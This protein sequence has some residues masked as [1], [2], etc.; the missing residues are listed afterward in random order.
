MTPD[1]HRLGLR[2]L[3]VICLVLGFSHL[4]VQAALPTCQAPAAVSH[5]VP[6]EPASHAANCSVLNIPDYPP[7]FGTHYGVWAKFQTY[8][9]PVSTGFWLHSAEH[10]AVV[11]L[12]K[13]PAGCTEEV[14]ALKALIETLPLDTACSNHP[15]FGAKRRIIMTPDPRLDSAFAI[16]A[17]GWS[18]KTNCLDTAALRAFYLA[19]I[20]Q[21]PEDFCNPGVDLSGS[22]WCN[23]TNAIHNQI[24]ARNPGTSN[25]IL[26]EG[27]L[28]NQVDLVLEISGLNGAR[29]ETISLGAAGP[30]VFRTYWN[31]QYMSGRNNQFGPVLCR[32]RVLGL[33]S[34]I[35]ILAEKI[36]QP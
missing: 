4:I 22:R 5:S 21:A 3:A 34:G 20:G 2:G 1:F 29:L 27:T 12:Y 31:P 28:A 15:E 32:I 36:I 24:E 16:V 14:T 10:G 26:W 23:E 18:L 19:H 30:G 17:W 7:T 13:C 35:P 8:S 9:Q 11:I 25:K 6:V 33:K